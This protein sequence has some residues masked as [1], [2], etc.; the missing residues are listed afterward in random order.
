VAVVGVIGLGKHQFQRVGV[1]FA[2]IGSAL[3]IA[4]LRV[5]SFARDCDRI[6]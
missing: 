1:V 2:P 3:G 4:V 6:E 5:K